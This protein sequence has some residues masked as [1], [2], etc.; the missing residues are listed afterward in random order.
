MVV[1]VLLIIAIIVGGIIVAYKP[2]NPLGVGPRSQSVTVLNGQLNLFT[3]Y[4]AANFTVPSGAQQ[5]KISVAFTASGGSGND[6]KFFV[7]TQ[8][9]FFKWANR[10]PY[11]AIRQTG[12]ITSFNED[13]SLP[14]SGDYTLV[15]DNSFS[16][17]TS[18][19]V[20]TTATLTYLL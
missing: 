2:Q 14:S 16:F 1:G 10:Q 20:Q 9:Q 6:I 15:Y 8:E 5:I 3:S 19:T 18:K 17:F 11:L 4:Y 7:L 12:Q 13:I